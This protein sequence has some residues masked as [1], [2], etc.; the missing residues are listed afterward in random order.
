MIN[1]QIRGWTLPGASI[2]IDF[3]IRPDLSRLADINVWADA[4]CKCI[5]S[6]KSY[7]IS[8]NFLIY[9]VYLKLK[10]SLH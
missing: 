2:G 7:R 9:T 4:A 5:L 10:F 3:Y 1:F 6:V 8:R